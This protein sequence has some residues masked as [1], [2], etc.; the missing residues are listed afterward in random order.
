MNRK[1]IEWSSCGNFLFFTNTSL[2]REQIRPRCMF[3]RTLQGGSHS[4]TSCLNLFC[5]K[6]FFFLVQGLVHLVVDLLTNAKLSHPVT[7][8]VKSAR[9]TLPL[10]M[11]APKLWNTRQKKKTARINIE[12]FNLSSAKLR[13]APESRRTRK[14]QLTVRLPCIIESER[15]GTVLT[16]EERERPGEKV[17]TYSKHPPRI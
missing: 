16:V 13:P 6:P 7:S 1:L 14:N 11:Q 15:Q 5:R 17:N 9:L 12:L 8:S 4:L 3:L 2:F 10:S